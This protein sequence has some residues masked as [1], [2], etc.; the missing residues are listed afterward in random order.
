M[1]VPLSA[2]IIPIVNYNEDPFVCGGTLIVNK[3]DKVL[4]LAQPLIPN[5]IYIWTSDGKTVSNKQALKVCTKK[6]GTLS[7]TVS[8]VSGG[9]TVQCSITIIIIIPLKVKIGAFINTGYQYCMDCNSTIVACQGDTIILTAEPNQKSIF[10]WRL[11]GREISRHQSINV[12][13][14]CP[15]ILEYDVDVVSIENP[16]LRFNCKVTIKI[17]C[18][19]N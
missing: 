14:C 1:S 9:Q 13:T 2:T 16:L 5:S 11:N 17:K 12:P 18:S 10:V 15:E 19:N 7:Y 3:R 8:V 6:Q 4:L